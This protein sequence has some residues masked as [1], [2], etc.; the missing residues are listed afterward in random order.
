M[1]RRLLLGASA[2]VFG[3]P[4]AYCRWNFRREVE[5]DDASP[6]DT[7]VVV[8]S[9]VFGVLTAYALATSPSAP[10]VVL[11]DAAGSV[12]AKAPAIPRQ[13]ASYGNACT[14]GRSSPVQNLSS[15]TFLRSLLFPPSERSQGEERT[16]KQ[17]RPQ[18]KF[19]NLDLILFD[20][21]FYRWATV[22]LKLV[23]YGYANHAIS[24]SSEADPLRAP[25]AEQDAIARHPVVG[26]F[27]RG[28]GRTIVD[29]NANV[30]KHYPLDAYGS[31]FHASSA[32]LRELVK[33]PNV[34]VRFGERAIAIRTIE[35]KT[36]RKVCGVTV[37]ASSSSTSMS[38]DASAVV[39]CAGADTSRL[40]LTSGF[41]VPIQ[42]LR[43]YSATVPLVAG[44]SLPPVPIVAKPHQ[45]YATPIVERNAVRFTCYGEMIPVIGCFERAPRNDLIEGL[46]NMIRDVYLVDSDADEEGEVCRMRR[47]DVEASNTI[48]IRLRWDQRELWWGSRPLTPDGAPLVGKVGDVSGLFVNS[49]GSFNGWRAS[50]LCAEILSDVVLGGT[51]V[52][53]DDATARD[54]AHFRRAYAPNRF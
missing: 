27:V 41:Y 7:I 10:K 54:V 37:T 30:R 52:S 53:R 6:P 18:N 44:S 24:P 35:A 11:V 12:S 40:L 1:I 47:L 22:W 13:S 36:K 39:V 16:D 20:T 50:A 38:I 33:L 8:G 9:G 23:I 17:T 29:T 4:L 45:L 25:R 31:C 21:F 28:A 46:E 19:L 5:N 48:P 2:G 3:V 34:E 15:H 51:R 14:L 49:G 32:V 43:G 42:P 26:S